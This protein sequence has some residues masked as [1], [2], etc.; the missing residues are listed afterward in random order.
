MLLLLSLTGCRYHAM[1]R[2]PGAAWDLS[3]VINARPTK[4]QAATPPAKLDEQ[5][6]STSRWKPRDPAEPNPSL[7]GPLPT[8]PPSSASAIPTTMRVRGQSPNPPQSTP[9]TTDLYRT[10]MQ[11]SGGNLPTPI[12]SMQPP[13]GLPPNLGGGYP[14][15]PSPSDLPAVQTNPFAGPSS[16]PI[17]SGIAPAPPMTE[18]WQ[19]NTAPAVPPSPSTGYQ[20]NVRDVPLGIYVQEAQTGKF[21]FGGTVNTDLGVAGQ[22]ILEERNFDI[23]KLP[24]SWR[25]LANGAFRG[26]GENFRLEAMPGNRVQRYSINWTQPNLFGYSP[27]S[28]SLGGFFFNRIYRDWDEQRL[29]ARGMLGYQITPDLSFSTELRGE[30][31]KIYQPR[32]AGVPQLDAVL[33]N[34]ELYTGRFR[35][36]HSTRDSIFI[37]T[38]GHYLE[39]IYDQVF[40][41]YDFPRGQVNYSKYFLIRERADGGGRHTLTNAWKVGL[42]G[43]QTP[44]FENYF[45]GGFTTMRGFSF[46]GASPVEGGVQ[47]GGRFMFLGTLEYM[48]PIT[49]DD[50][51]RMMAFVD[52]G[53]IEQ[54]IKLD[55]DNFRVAPGVGL[56]ISVPALG[57]GPLAFDLAFPVSSAATD[58]KQV[59]SFSVGLSK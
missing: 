21:V 56:R 15:A 5:G 7:N 50:M 1:Q 27:W 43:A 23:M 25:D 18:R 58:D 16:G 4:G 17:G 39:L 9:G 49:A 37:P 29:G 10:P 40:G 47:V 45:A 3:Q 48:M 34:N 36:A 11:A 57:P 6:G 44:L 54:D 41:T 28:L 51:L 26:N 22:I 32:V 20:P 46:R 55:W 14:T 53:T 31:V 52:Y 8:D 19:Y 13:N 24:K 42:S 33:G 12:T 35:L 30:S 38:E 59:F 2:D